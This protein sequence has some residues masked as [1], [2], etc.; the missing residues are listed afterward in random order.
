MQKGEERIVGRKMVE[1]CNTFYWRTQ[2]LL[3]SLSELPSYSR[4]TSIPMESCVHNRTFTSVNHG[5]SLSS[6]HLQ[7]VLAYLTGEI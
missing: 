1:S 7:G 3:G 4:G 2:I 5:L 6:L